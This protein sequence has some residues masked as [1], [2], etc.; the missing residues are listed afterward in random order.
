MRFVRVK[1]KRE[2]LSNV[3]RQES[4]LYFKKMQQNVFG[5]K[6]VDLEKYHVKLSV[7]TE[8]KEVTNT[9]ENV[10]KKKNF[11]RKSFKINDVRN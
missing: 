11:T 10:S 8:K 3:F 5:S 6:F 9:K 2:F 7:K 4:I 1:G